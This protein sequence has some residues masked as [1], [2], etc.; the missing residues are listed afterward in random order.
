MNRLIIS[1]SNN[2]FLNYFKNEWFIAIFILV[3]SMVV[4]LVLF[5]YPASVV[6]DEV[7]IGHYITEYL[8]G[9][10]MFDVHPPLGR[11]IFVFFAIIMG[12]TSDVN[13]DHI[14]NILPE[15]AIFLRIVPIV[16]GILLPIVVYGILRY[17]NIPKHLSL[18]GGILLCIENSLIVQSRFLLVDS[19]LILFGFISILV[20]F[21]YRSKINEVYKYKVI[22]LFI[23]IL[24]ASLAFCIKWTG[25][26]FILFIIICEIHRRGIRNSIKFILASLFELFIIYAFIFSL[27]F[28][29]LP[30]SGSGDDFM[31][32]EFQKTLIGNKYYDDKNI[33]PLKF[34]Q[35]FYEVNIE[36]FKANTRLNTPHSYSSKWY[37]WPLEYRPI[38]YWNKVDSVDND[39]ESYIYL[40]GNPIIYWIGFISIIILL[41]FIL[42]NKIYKEGSDYFVLLGFLINFIPFI[43][44][45]RVMF[46]YH[47]QVALVFS[48][49]AIIIVL[50]KI[51][52]QKI[53][54][55]M[56]VLITI[57]SFILFIYFSP[58]TYGLPISQS[59]LDS[60]MW[61]N[62]WR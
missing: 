62:S 2:K 31:S 23:S 7:H 26:S 41:I 18:L 20:Y 34:W 6:F 49:M 28:T 54:N 45:G 10:Y 57:S 24:F 3:F 21:Y 60:R 53:K 56:I 17:W 33:K 58:L 37:T 35:S 48:C 36:M 13:F 14:G 29:L 52:N 39:I 5:G 16:S 55:I 4:H 19:I 51:N 11:L 25:L 61:L 22:I 50:N 40:I 1:L 12:A 32:P 43:Y 42:K 15:W 59:K 46:L 30:N 38:Y 44:I 8:K 27:H 9:N 47:Y